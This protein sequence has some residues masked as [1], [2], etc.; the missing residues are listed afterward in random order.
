MIGRADDCN[1]PIAHEFVS[2]RH[3]EVRYEDGAWHIHDLGSRNGLLVEG[4]RTDSAIIGRDTV[5]QFG[6]EGPSITLAPEIQTNDNAADV[7]R[8]STTDPK[9]RV[10]IDHYLT[11]RSDGDAA[12]ERTIMV[13]RAF[14]H[15]QAKQRRRFAWIVGALVL[16]MILITAYAIRQHRQTKAQAELARQLFYSIKSLD[17]EIAAFQRLVV[18]SDD[19]A[20]ARASRYRERRRQMEA[21]Y[22]RFLN[23]LRIYDPKVTPEERLILRVA[24]IFGECELS[25]PPDFVSEVKNYIRKWQSSPRLAA[26]IRRAQENG[27]TAVIAKELLRQGLPVQ[28]FYLAL[29]ESNF[30]PWAIGPPTYKGIAKGMWQFIPETAARYGL[31]VGPLLEMQRPD[32]ADGRHH[33]ERATAAAA[34][35]LKDLYTDDA[36]ASGMLVMACYNWGEDRVLPL[37]R[38]MPANP[39]SRNFWKLLQQYRNKLPKETYDYVFYIVSAAAIGENP[40]MFQFDFDNPLA[41]LEAR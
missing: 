1:V 20:D 9:V 24:R 31:R 26:G 18:G 16:L 3:A 23:A 15:L 32:P 7:F 29:Q 30:D 10:Y 37:V 6:V 36:Q 33:W 19:V 40:R 34:Q 39:Q 21:D 28:F 4:V 25:A 5:V 2:R 14:L 13:R 17:V 12:G 35:Y 22:D 8:S 11:A 41:H 38:S 27:Y